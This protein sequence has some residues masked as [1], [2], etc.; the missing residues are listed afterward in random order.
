MLRVSE[1]FLKQ[2]HDN[3]ATD[4]Y[5]SLSI[6]GYR[7]THELIEQ[8]RAGDWDFEHVPPRCEVLPDAMDTLFA[9]LGEEP[10]P[11]LRAVAGHWLFGYI[12]PHRDGNGRIARFLMNAMLASGGYPWTVIRVEDR[13][14][15][16]AALESASVDQ[17]LGPFAELLAQSVRNHGSEV[18]AGN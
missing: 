18:D 11:A 1:R 8:V 9:L 2:A 13:G 12:H 10:H 7:V 5:H 3:Y 16:L 15:Y 6:E 17:D 4:A 14:K